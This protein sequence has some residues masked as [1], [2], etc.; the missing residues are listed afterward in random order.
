MQSPNPWRSYRQAATQTASPG[1]LVLMLLDGANQFL[2]C[3][4]KGFDLDDPAEFNQTIH[5]N[6]LRAQEIIR[7]LNSSLDMTQ[8]GQVAE[9]LRGLY[10]YFD[11]RLTESNL[12]KVPEGI[13]EVERHLGELREGWDTMLKQQRA[14]APAACVA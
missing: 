2:H 4:L 3:A 1:Q 11:R 14:L 13:L 12:R 5:N 7:E 9:E 8:G 10:A 6:V